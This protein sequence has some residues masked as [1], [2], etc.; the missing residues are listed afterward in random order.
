MSFADMGTLDIFAIGIDAAIILSYLG[1]LIYTYS[2]SE[3]CR[4][5]T[6][7]ANQIR[8]YRYH[9][10]TAVS[11][12][13]L[14]AYFIFGVN[15]W[16]KYPLLLLFAYSTIYMLKV[17]LPAW[18]CKMKKMLGTCAC[19]YYEYDDLIP[20]IVYATITNIIFASV[21]WTLSSSG[22]YLLVLLFGA[23]LVYRFSPKKK[24]KALELPPELVMKTADDFQ[25]FTSFE[26]EKA[27]IV[28]IASNSCKFCDFQVSE[29]N[30]IPIHLT[31]NRLRVL[32][33]TDKKDVDLMILFALNLDKSLNFFLP[34]SFVLN[35]GICTNQKE[36]AMLKQEIEEIL[37]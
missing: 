25:K 16:L 11:S 19:D 32:D 26:P 37:S 5:I 17:S 36:G 12:S 34:M 9:I 1:Y 20:M 8:L 31:K 15:Y 4:L 10:Y 33:I 14:V 24:I 28:I 21:N 2:Q 13:W 23:Y 27:K 35:G 6:I 30:A 29:I 3:N 18:I 22:I 7:K